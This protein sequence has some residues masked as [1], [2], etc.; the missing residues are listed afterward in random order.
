MAT[1]LLRNKIQ[2]PGSAQTENV[3]LRVPK[4]NWLRR[5]A[6]TFPVNLTGL[7]A[8]PLPSPAGLTRGSIQFERLCERDGCAGIADKC[9]QCAQA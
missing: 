9:T 6:S 1:R 3:D 7:S 5:V 4:S 2:C 8:N